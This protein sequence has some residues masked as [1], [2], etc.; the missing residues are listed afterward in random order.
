[1]RAKIVLAVLFALVVGTVALVATRQ[2]TDH[3]APV[4]TAASTASS[5]LAATSGSASA[6]TPGP[7]GSAD[8][9]APLFDRP[10]R[11]VALGWDA[12]VPAVLANRGLEPGAD[13]AFAKAGL[14]VRLSPVDTMAIVESAL[15]R[16]GADKDGAD[17][18]IVPLPAFVASYERLRALGLEIFLVTSWSRGREAVVAA[19][20]LFAA[21][22]SGDIRVGGAAGDGATLLALFAL[23]AA[24]VP[25]SS[26]KL[27]PLPVKASEVVLEAV[28]R[29]TLTDQALEGRKVLLTTADA[30]RLV[31]WVA[32][33]PHGLVAASAPALVTWTRGFMEGQR[34]L[35][36]D[37]PGAAREV[38]AQKNAPEPLSLLRRLGELSQASLVDNTTVMGLSG[39]GGVRLDAL[40]QDA[41]RL[42]RAVGVLATPAPESAPIGTQIVAAAARAE[43]GLVPPAPAA[44]KSAP[45]DKTRI[46]LAYRAPEGKIDEP[47]LV[48]R[49]GMLAGLF[50]KSSLRITVRGAAGVDTPRTKK[51]VEAVQG[52]FDIAP[53]RLVAGTKAEGKAAASV[54]VLEVP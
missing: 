19:R 35:A 51:L 8:G 32:V 30:S 53:G 17:I 20:E 52:Q 10:L 36:T 29:G 11:T 41:W 49:V 21:P 43:P 5:A 25:S 34:K 6:P 46:L 50:E 26:V 15:A 48:A 14:D 28:D 54:E 33:A 13:G 40:F 9:G 24:G 1:M 4:P 3:V 38:A 39:R 45:T 16:G 47:A 23:D 42:W 7:A 27:V 44:P 18:A 37:A 31:P 22:P 12:L 2:R